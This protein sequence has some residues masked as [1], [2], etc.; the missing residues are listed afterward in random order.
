MPLKYC[1]QNGFLISL[2]SL[3]YRTQGLNCD[4]L[5]SRLPDPSLPFYLEASMWHN[6]GHLEVNNSTHERFCLC[7]WL[8]IWNRWVK[9]LVI[10]HPPT[11]ACLRMLPAIFQTRNKTQRQKSQLHEDVRAKSQLHEDGRAKG[12]LHRDDRAKGQLYE[13]DR[14]KWQ[15]F[16]LADTSEPVLERLFISS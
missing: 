4:F 13:Y 6:S 12:Q 10:I 3:A 7:Y 15:S 14:A 8:L 5:L 16:G 1:T 9:K 2:Y 11:T